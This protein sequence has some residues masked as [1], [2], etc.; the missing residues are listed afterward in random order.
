MG[1]AINIG[2]GGAIAPPPCPYGS[3]GPV[4]AAHEAQHT[5]S[6]GGG[7][8]KLRSGLRLFLEKLFRSA[9]SMALCGEAGG[10]GRRRYRRSTRS[11]RTPVAEWS[12]QVNY[13]K[14]EFTK[15]IF[16]KQSNEKTHVIHYK[17]TRSLVPK[18]NY[19][20][21]ENFGEKWSIRLLM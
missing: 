7:E 16:R 20:G 5:D 18:I 11:R 14:S 10:F 19:C 17:C 6:C 9:T 12:K 21:F 3:Y 2:G 13:V 8:N 4:C 15:I 1:G